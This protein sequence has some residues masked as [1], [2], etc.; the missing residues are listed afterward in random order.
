VRVVYDDTAV[1]VAVDCVQRTTPVIA[2]LSRR[3]R[4]V[5]S[6]W[7][8]AALG[9]NGDGKTA[10]EFRVNAARAPMLLVPLWV[11][12]CALIYNAALVLTSSLL[13]ARRVSGRLGDVRAGSMAVEQMRALARR[14]P[15][16]RRGCC[17]HLGGA[18]H[19]GSRL[20]QLSK[21]RELS[22]RG[23]YGAG[24]RLR[25]PYTLVPGP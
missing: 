13:S 2:R 4:H 14:S 25:I 16:P 19:V 24:E 5:E 8:S 7:L 6:D 9:T 15:A 20:A 11:L 12:S 18:P 1:Y 3:D 17:G 23:G 10:Y 21:H 22:F